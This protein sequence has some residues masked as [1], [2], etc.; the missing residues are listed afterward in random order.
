MKDKL[1]IDEKFPVED[2]SS[3]ID[4]KKQQEKTE[5]V[6]LESSLKILKV[7]NY[8][9]NNKDI[10]SERGMKFVMEGFESATNV[11]TDVTMSTSL[12]PESDDTQ[13]TDLSLTIGFAEMETNLFH[14]HK[15]DTYLQKSIKDPYNLVQGISA[16]MQQVFRN[17]PYL[18]PFQTKLLYF[19]LVSFISSIDVHRSIYFLR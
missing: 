2:K 10:I 13:M 6:I 8:I 12:A 9:Y 18:F 5:K 7:I 19:K 11:D 14:N 4:K 15:L 16:E 1:I 17:C 3:A